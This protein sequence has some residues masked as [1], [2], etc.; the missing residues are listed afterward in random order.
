MD[1]MIAKD[2]NHPSVVM[3]SVGNEISELGTAEGQELCRKLADEVRR[4]DGTRAVTCGINL[5]LASMAAKGKGIYG[6]DKEGK[7]NKNGSST[8]DSVPTSTMFNVMMNRM[9]GII[10]RMASTSGADK[11]ADAIAPCL[12]IAGYNYATSRYRKEAKKHHALSQSLRHCQ[13]ASTET[14]NWSKLCRI[15]WE[16]LCGPPGTIS[17]RPASEPCAIQIRRQS[18]IRI[19]G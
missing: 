19:R 14:G 11:A 3:Y 4:Q 16:I 8:M 10:D 18:R 17:G 2:Y 12:D 15:W 7:E 9:G 13:R 1:A 5:M 6:T